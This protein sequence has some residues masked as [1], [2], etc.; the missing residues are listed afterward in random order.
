MLNNKQEINDFETE[1]NYLFSAEKE[2]EQIVDDIFSEL[3]DILDPRDYEN[4]KVENEIVEEDNTPIPLE[5]ELLSEITPKKE[6][7]IQQKYFDSTAF[8]EQEVLQENPGLIKH[9]DKL[10]FV[11]SF[12][13]LVAVIGWLISIDK[14]KV[15]IFGYESQ[16]L[17]P[18]ANITPSQDTEFANYLLQSLKIIDKETP[19]ISAT[20]PQIDNSKSEE[21]IPPN[22]DSVKQ[23]SPTRIIERIY[24]PFAQPIPNPP[25]TP[26]PT[27]P[28]IQVRNT[29][30]PPPIQVRNT[31][32]PPPIQVRNTP[33]APPIQVKT[34]PP[35]VI[36]PT[37]PPVAENKVETQVSEVAN[38]VTD[39]HT[40][41]GL[42]ELGDR[43]AALFEV[44]GI[45]RRIY[46][47]ENIGSSGWAVESVAND[48]V[49]INRKGQVR[50]L[51]VGQ[52]F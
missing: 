23:N 18:V 17:V 42:L 44:G 7:I 1:E 30:T 29:P 24:I 39:S 10:L 38:V 45:T 40:L 43:S 5:A 34:P 47:G 15:P 9:L 11:G 52:E 51:S 31:P 50:S 20:Q 27:P 3:D 35:P 14:I 19:L 12:S 37:P 6:E 21:K 46:V 49:V 25:P 48:K 26:T 16:E 4:V 8:A 2:A 41:I 13:F 33:I 36:Q 32:T 28:P 22:N